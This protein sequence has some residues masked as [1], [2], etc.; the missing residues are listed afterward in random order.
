LGA[1]RTQ[2]LGVI[3]AEYLFLG[4]IAGAAGTLLGVMA[5]W[6]LS[7][8]FFAVPALIAPTPM[9]VIFLI[10]TAATVITGALGSWGIFQSSPLEALRAE[11]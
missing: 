7:V 8:Y 9:V 10:V 6:G 1:P 3:A 5:T 4:G 2:I 11:A